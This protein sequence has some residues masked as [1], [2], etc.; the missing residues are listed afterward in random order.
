MNALYNLA[1]C[2]PTIL[3]VDDDKSIVEFLCSALEYKGCHVMS[4]E[5]G[6]AA[7]KMYKS[8]FTKID[9][10]IM[11]LLMP[12]MNGWEVLESMRIINHDLKAII[13]SGYQGMIERLEDFDNVSGLL[14]KPVTMEQLFDGIGQ[15]LMPES[16]QPLSSSFA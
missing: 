1:N 3:V 4:A 2:A 14:H 7:I 15:A 5:D 6:P 11:D 16:Q 9:L 12:G 8:N 10:V 13:I